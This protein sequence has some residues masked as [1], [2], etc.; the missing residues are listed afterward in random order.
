MQA[1]LSKLIT[2]DEFMEMPDPEDGSQ[3][4]LVRGK[5]VDMPLPQGPHGFVC[6]K[7]N[8]L[9]G[10]YSDAKRLGHVLSND[11]GVILDRHPDTVRGP[12]VAFWSFA[13][14]PR[15]PKGYIEIA[16]D[17][18]V[19][20]VSPGNSQRKLLEKV[21]DYFFGGTRRVWAIYPEDR[22]VTIFH[23]PIEAKFLNEQDDLDGE[24]VLPGFRCKVADLF[25]PEEMPV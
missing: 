2:A 21:K 24:D 22:M 5:V 8:R 10:N 15:I 6:S 9:I 20:V 17:L 13:R 18:A 14:L 3:Q 11:T 4:E 16:P 12:D 25:P 19:E 7:I 23:S 1:T